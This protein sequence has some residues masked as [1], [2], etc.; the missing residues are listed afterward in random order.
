MEINPVNQDMR[1]FEWL[2]LWKDMVPLDHTVSLLQA[3]FFPKWL[4]VFEYY[5]FA[6]STDPQSY[7]FLLQ[8]TFFIII[9][10]RFKN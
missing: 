2:M 1:A 4:Q 7:Y 8:D 5:Y 10:I 9:K 3:I 6:F